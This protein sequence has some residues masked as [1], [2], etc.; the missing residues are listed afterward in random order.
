MAIS[1]NA[2]ALLKDA[3]FWSSLRRSSD[4][5]SH[6]SPVNVWLFLVAFAKYRKATV[7]FV[8]SVRPYGTV[9]TGRIFMKIYISRGS[10]ENIEAS[11]KPVRE[12]HMNNNVHLWS[13]LAQFFLEWEMFQTKAVEKIKTH[14]L[15]SVTF[16]RK[17]R[18]LWDNVE[19]KCYRAGQATGDKMIRRMRTACWIPKATDHTLALSICNT[20][21]FPTAAMVTRWRRIINV[22]G[23]CLFLLC[24]KICSKYAGVAFARHRV[25]RLVA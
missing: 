19:K 21:C 8:V 15:C 22:T 9:P 2:L 3:R 23:H 4:P 25:W 16:L 5:V 24:T 17:S 12:Y 6:L 18:R 13:H 7:S 1:K 14:I 10:V 11:P 20:Y